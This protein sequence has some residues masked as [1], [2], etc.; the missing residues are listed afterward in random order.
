MKT[1]LS[2]IAIALFAVQ[3]SHSEIVVIE[4]DLDGAEASIDP[5]AIPNP[6]GGADIAI[7]PAITLDSGIFDARFANADSAGT[8]SDGDSSI[9]GTGFEGE[10]SIELNSTIEVLG[11]DVPVSATISGPFMAQQV[12][13]SDGMLTGLSVYVETAPGDYDVSAGPLGCSDS[14]F[15]VF[16]TAI[17]TG[18][19]IDFPAGELSSTNPLPFTGGT[20]TDLNP[21]PASGISSVT[22]QI[23]FSFPINDDISFGVE[24]NSNWVETGRMTFVPEP[25]AVALLAAGLSGAFRRRR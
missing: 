8:I 25:S 4:Y 17:E 24:I 21:G 16:C 13:D 6:Q 5:F 22:S 10:I 14:A 1:T 19:G 15:G 7:A 12:T 9:I 23:D 11:F 18:L 3:A 2:S 20:F